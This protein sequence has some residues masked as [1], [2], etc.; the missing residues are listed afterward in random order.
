MDEDKERERRL[1]SE[2]FDRRD[3]AKTDKELRE[4][5]LQ[6][7][8]RCF[9]DAPDA[10]ALAVLLHEHGHTYDPGYDHVGYLAVNCELFGVLEESNYN[11]NRLRHWLECCDVHCQVPNCEV[12]AFYKKAKDEMSAEDRRRLPKQPYCSCGANGS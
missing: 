11:L 9:P 12:V 4:V 6:E 1:L 8:E 5:E 10:R 7:I 3:S 2:Y